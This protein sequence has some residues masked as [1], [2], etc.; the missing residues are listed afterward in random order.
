MVSS[1]EY[2]MTDNRGTG[3]LERGRASVKVPCQAGQMV[4]L[5]NTPSVKGVMVVVGIREDGFDVA[6]SNPE[7]KGIFG[8]DLI[9]SII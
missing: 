8:W 2:T 1:G 5:H 9:G 3:L 7:D 4:F 6:S